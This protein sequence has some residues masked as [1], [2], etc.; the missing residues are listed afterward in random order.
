MTNDK[1]NEIA[2]TIISAADLENEDVGGLQFLDVRNITTILTYVVKEATG[3]K[4]VYGNRVDYIVADEFGEYV[5]SSWNF[6][7]K[8][9]LKALQLVGKK[10]TIQPT[11]NNKKV[12]L[13]VLD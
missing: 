9:K 10:I 3:K 7:T 13:N 2:E 11:T 5:L 12:L 1:G 4:T 6:L 8:S